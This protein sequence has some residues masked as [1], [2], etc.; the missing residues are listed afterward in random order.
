MGPF[1]PKSGKLKVEDPLPEPY[2]VPMMLNKA[3]YVVLE[4]ALP[5]HNNQPVGAEPAPYI[6][7]D[8]EGDPLTVVQESVPEPSVFST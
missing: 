4:T 1:P 5:S 6:V 3:E 2:V 8:P 7:I